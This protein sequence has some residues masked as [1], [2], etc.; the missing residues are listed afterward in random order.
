VSK[1]GRTAIHIARPHAAQLT[2]AELYNVLVGTAS[3]DS[4]KED[5]TKL[6]KGR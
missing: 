1:V 4:T 6:T 2:S 3:P 5:C